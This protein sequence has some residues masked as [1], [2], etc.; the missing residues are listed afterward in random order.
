MIELKQVTLTYPGA[1]RPVLREVSLNIGEGELVLVIGHTGSGKS[2]LLRLL[3][4]LAPHHTGGSL[5]GDVVINGHSI[6]ERKP[7]ELASLVGIV[8]QDPMDGFVADVV[9]E[10]IAFGMES[11]GIAPEVMRKRVEEVLD[12]LSLAPLRRR[13]LSTLSGGEQ[14]RV[15]I[16]SAL[17][18]HPR[19]LVLDEP[20]SALDPNAAD[21]VLSTVHRLVHDLGITVVMAEHRLERVIQYVDRIVHVLGDGTITEGSAAEMMA[22]SPLSPP[23]IELARLAGWDPLP[24]TVRDARRLAEPLRQQLAQHTVTIAPAAKPS[25]SPLVGVA[26]ATV[27][28][29]NHTAL[30]KVDLH[31]HAGEIVAVMGRNGAG[32]S[33][34]LTTMVGLRRPDHGSISLGGHDPSTLSGPSLIHLAGLVPQESG[35]LLYA[36]SVAQECAF[37]DRDA[38]VVAGS[39][40]AVLDILAPEVHGDQHP[41][42]LSEGERLSLALAVVL[43]ASPPLILLDEPTRGLD[44]RSKSRLASTLRR[45]A[46]EGHAVV[47]AT[48]DVE[49]VAEVASRVI[50]LADGD[51][52]AD[53]PT[54]EVVTASPSFAPQI[55]KVLAP[56]PWLTVADVAAALQ[57]DRQ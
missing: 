57:R 14:Q 3:N 28:F 32:K 7:R 44:Y 47:F 19:V 38:G 55:A 18:T 41:R 33:T 8:G 30:R 35:D 1:D 49:L 51:V 20:T 6:R 45:L 31:V 13:V 43:A 17:V 16:A 40:R 34:L 12:L 10:E 15:A 5:A 36:D 9:E 24:L 22:H 48:H 21:E 26:G 4:G 27:R 42:D 25:T 46:H 23:V 37:A 53:G 39:A 29:G 56:E 54:Q 2:S 52:V 11:Q 50:V